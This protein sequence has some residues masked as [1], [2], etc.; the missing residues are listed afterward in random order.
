[1]KLD[2][3]SI[4]GGGPAGHGAHRF[5]LFAPRSTEPPPLDDARH[6]IRVGIITA[7]LFFGLLLLFSVA[8]P[9][10]GAAVASGEVATA[11]TA[12]VV[13]PETSG[14][15][16]QVLV[17]EG[18]HVAAGQPLVRMNGVRSGAAAEQAQAKRDA[19]RALQARLIAER[20]GA[21][22]VAFPP[23]L[24][25]RMA[26]PNVASAV[27]AQNAI[28]KRHHDI[29][30]ADRS[31]AVTQSDT[32]AAQRS[33][34]RKQLALIN[35]ELAGIRQLYAKGYAR[36]TQ[37]RSLERA[38]AELQ[39]ESAT[40]GSSVARSNLE[41]AKLADE[42][43]M[44]TVS[45]LAQVDEQLAQVDPALRVTQYDANRDVLR[46][47]A[48]GRV[49]GLAKI[50]PGT[51]LGGGRTVMELV[52]DGRALIVEANIKPADIDDVRVGSPATLRFTTINPRGSSSFNG[53]VVALSPMQ[54]TTPQGAAYFR[55]QIAV[56]DPAA[57]KRE[58]VALRPGVP[59]TVH[60]KTHAR[61]L[62]DYLFTPL[63]DAA[64]GAFREE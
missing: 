7:A 51:V 31:I 26:D 57:L 17:S 38:A 54:L 63:E 23:D 55:A 2:F 15:V 9:I 21:D 14:L 48:A 32:A 25:Q 33:G 13:Q 49:S 10:S 50:G 8:A 18:Q 41:R 16:T 47:P 64:S 42:Q 40:A 4:G 52:P 44:Q 20:D 3:L 60:V 61:T 29:L 6:I 28:F 22:T 5:D 34:A 58:H 62:F 19:L 35:D 45:Q 53:K 30:A 11:G 39:A 12:I 56:S 36:K 24:T 37:V 43:T 1:M 46:A 59:V 27:A